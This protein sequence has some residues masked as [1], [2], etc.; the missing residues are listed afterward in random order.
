MVCRTVIDD[1]YLLWFIKDRSI[2]MSRTLLAMLVLFLSAASVCAQVYR[3]D[4][5]SGPVFS[6]IPCAPDARPVE[7]IEP[8][9]GSFYTVPDN[10]TLNGLRLGMSQ[11]G[12]RRALGDPSRSQSQ[13]ERNAIIVSWE[14]PRRVEAHRPYGS[15]PRIRHPEMTLTFI[16]DELSRI[17]ETSSYRPRDGSQPLGSRPLSKELSTGLSATEVRRSIGPPNRE[18]RTISREGDTMHWSYSRL[19]RRNPFAPQLVA[20]IY[21]ALE[22][23][24]RDQTLVRIEEGRDR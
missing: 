8:S 3:C 2:A 6:Q 14:Y 19:V 1:L 17:S 11:A 5:P 7:S 13:R 18:R 16:N 12:V 20:D 21:P 4:G 24:F 15:A 9:R 22:L 10:T 23:T